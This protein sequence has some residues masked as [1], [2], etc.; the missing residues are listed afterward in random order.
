MLDQNILY[1]K[2]ICAKFEHPV[3]NFLRFIKN[4][5][6]VNMTQPA[7]PVSNT[8]PAQRAAQSSQVK[9]SSQ[10]GLSETPTT[11]SS[12]S[13]VKKET[14]KS[15]L[16]KALDFFYSII[17]W[18]KGFFNCIKVSVNKKDESSS[19]AV[20]KSPTEAL[21][22]KGASIINRLL[23]GTTA[24]YLGE[25]QRR[26]VFVVSINGVKVVVHSSQL[27]SATLQEVNDAVTAEMDTWINNQTNLSNHA[28][29][30]IK[31]ILVETVDNRADTRISSAWETLSAESSEG[32]NRGNNS[33]EMFL[34]PQEARNLFSHDIC[35][36]R[37]AD[38]VSSTRN[39]PALNFL[40][41]GL[42]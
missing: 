4:L 17:E 32:L 6:G 39:L 42:A 8:T 13:K 15:F 23:D 18:F 21:K 20:A 37:A 9:G 29:I 7:S 34:S 24:T 26:A 31:L 11:L 28:K 36:E 1:Q 35:G 5:K 16:Q 2:I 33:Y 10:G 27:S 41:E 22:E 25:G 38:Q 19:N 40:M 12:A 3:N 30:S 14:S